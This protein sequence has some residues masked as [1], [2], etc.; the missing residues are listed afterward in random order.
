VKLENEIVELQANPL[1][2]LF[3]VEALRLIAF[4]S[5]IRTYRRDDTLFREGDV[6]DG[7][8]FVISGSVSLVST[9][10]E[11]TH[12]PYALIGEAA[13]F[14]ETRRPANATALE[15]TEVRRIPRHLVRRI[16]AEFPSSAARLHTHLK[17]KV[18]SLGGQLARIEA[19]L[20]DGD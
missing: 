6:S 17:E 19:L 10:S 13:L 3:D 8:L 20:P 1:L 4:S 12:G 15:L 7:G 18:S 14:T 5:D 2:A 11:E 9:N 16:L